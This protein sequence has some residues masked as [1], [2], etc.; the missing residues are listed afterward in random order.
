M[1][2]DGLQISLNS[3][4][5]GILGYH[6]VSLDYL[7]AFVAWDLG[8]KDLKQISLNGL[9]HSSIDSDSIKSLRNLVFEDKWR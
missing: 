7:I 8:L 3:G 6:D 1:M 2:A 5:P 9:N 4:H